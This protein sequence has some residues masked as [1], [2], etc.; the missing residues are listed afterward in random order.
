MQVRNLKLNRLC[1]NLKYLKIMTDQINIHK[2]AFLYFCILFVHA[3]SW[4]IQYYILI[5]FICTYWR[6][7]K[8]RQTCSGIFIDNQQFLSK[9]TFCW[10]SFMWLHK[11]YMVI[12]TA[13]RRAIDLNLL[14]KNLKVLLRS[15]TLIP[16]FFYLAHTCMDFV[17]RNICRH[18]EQ[19]TMYPRRH[20]NE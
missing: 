8:F 13:I 14:E 3:V 15:V 12:C 7:G 5:H 17:L 1:T 16:I 20:Y 19:A 4:Y 6:L 9:M 10:L 11:Q 2:Y 18:V